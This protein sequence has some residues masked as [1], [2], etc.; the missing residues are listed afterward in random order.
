MPG[1]PAGGRILVPCL[2]DVETQACPSTEPGCA[3]P[4]LGPGAQAPGLSVLFLLWGAVSLAML[5]A[6][7]TFLL[8]DFHGD[9]ERILRGYHPPFSGLFTEGKVKTCKILPVSWRRLGRWPGQGCGVKAE[10]WADEW[11]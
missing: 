4:G 11:S 7:A 1:R 10:H 3:G 6:F 5:D 8:L 2:M 9:S